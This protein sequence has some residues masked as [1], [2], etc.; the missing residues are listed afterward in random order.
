MTRI[1]RETVRLA[2]ARDF[3]GGYVTQAQLS[4]R[5]EVSR[6]TVSRWAKR[7]IR[8]GI[9]GVRRTV[10][11]GRP[12]ALTKAQKIKLRKLYSEG[13][14]AHGYRKWTARALQAVIL[15]SSSAFV[16]TSTTF[17]DCAIHWTVIKRCV[18]KS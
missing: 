3:L 17:A 12:S 6:T 14:L 10:T 11:P 15:Q 8:R 9:D 2:A 13:P 7:I 4:R 5:Y 18:E 1:E 16:T